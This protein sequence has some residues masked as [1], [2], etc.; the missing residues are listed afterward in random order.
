MVQQPPGDH[1]L[2]QQHPSKV[3]L[4]DIYFYFLLFFYIYIILLL[5]VILP[6][7]YIGLIIE[8]YSQDIY[9]YIYVY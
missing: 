5:W 6:N 7:G 2:A 8:E 9:I 4:S 1:N 3:S